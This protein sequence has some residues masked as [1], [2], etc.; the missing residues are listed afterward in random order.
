MSSLSLTFL[1]QIPVINKFS[2]LNLQ[3][4][5]RTKSWIS[6]ITPTATAWSKLS[7]SLTRNTDCHSLFTC[8]LISIIVPHLLEGSSRKLSHI[9]LFFPSKLSNGSQLLQS[10]VQVTYN[11]L[12]YLRGSGPFA[13]CD[14]S[15]FPFLTDFSLS[16]NYL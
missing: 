5:S 2:W 13:P 11:S 12:R 8:L 6:F 16:S 7:L 10:K 9:V 14:F 1:S 15:Q 3:K 4:R